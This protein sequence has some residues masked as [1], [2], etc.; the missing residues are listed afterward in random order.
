MKEYTQVE[1]IEKLRNMLEQNLISQI[2]YNTIV[3]LLNNGELSPDEICTG[4][5][6]YLEGMN[7]HR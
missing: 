5:I 2:Q 1:T 3:E 7:R 4:Y 6:P